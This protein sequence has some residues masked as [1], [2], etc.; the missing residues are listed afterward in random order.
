MTAGDRCHP[1]LTRRTAIFDEQRC[2]TRVSAP[3]ILLRSHITRARYCHRAV[4]RS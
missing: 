3:T 2:V 1:P 4:K